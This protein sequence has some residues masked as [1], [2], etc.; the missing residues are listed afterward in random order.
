M[1]TDILV[2]LATCNGAAFLEA[3]LASLNTQDYPHWRLLARDDGSTDTTPQILRAWAA[4]H[5]DRI[6]LLE[7]GVGRQ[8]VVGNFSRLLAACDAPGFMFCDQDDVWLPDKLATFAERMAALESRLGSDT[9]IL[10]HSDLAVVDQALA[11]LAAS[12][13]RRQGLDVRRDGRF[14][15]LLRGNVVT[16]CACMGN[17]ALLRLAVPIPA[18]AMMHDWWLALVAAAVGHVDVL[19]RATVLYR[20]HEAN[21]IGSRPEG[22]PALLGV[23]LRH[24]HWELAAIPRRLRRRQMQARALAQRLGT[25]MAAERRAECAGFIAIHGLRDVIERVRD[26]WKIV[27]QQ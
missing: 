14:R 15:A 22:W 17:A 12:Y 4:R 20:Q 27:Q 10:I 24:P 11:P 26:V 16:G 9:P 3:Q 25:R 13:W 19:D 7:D 5:P 1:K 2:L 18:E 23:W 21:Q 8:G 6:T